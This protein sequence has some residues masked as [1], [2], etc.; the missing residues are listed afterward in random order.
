MI[1][2]RQPIS[3]AESQQYI[4]KED[5]EISGFIQKFKVIKAKDALEIREKIDGLEIMKIRPEHI[6]KLI[7]I[8][9][10]DK[11]ELNKVFVDIGLDEDESNKI[12]DIVKQYK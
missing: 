5:S 11:E 8:L 2:D 7:D 9:P 10:E 6:A 1:I 4:D 12:L 3:M